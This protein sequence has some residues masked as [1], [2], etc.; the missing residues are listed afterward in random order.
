MSSLQA[1][2]SNAKKCV[3]RRNFRPYARLPTPFTHIPLHPSTQPRLVV[4]F[5]GRFN[6]KHKELVHRAVCHS[7]LRFCA[8]P[9]RQGCVS[10][11][12]SSFWLFFL[13]HTERACHTIVVQVISSL[14]DHTRDSKRTISKT[15][16]IQPNPSDGSFTV[17]AS[18]AQDVS[19]EVIA[20][21]ISPSGKLSAILRETTS[22]DKKRFVEV[23]EGERLE[24]SVNVTKTH[25]AFYAD[26][27]PSVLLMSMHASQY[28]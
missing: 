20:S 17:I 6:R 11:R 4:L 10:I 2:T 8:V 28:G 3:A 27:E 13:K 19:P 14:Q 12:R 18:T 5:H 21:A 24:V 9:F 26:G 16:F 1:V 23:W 25:G 15:F 7:R 22:G